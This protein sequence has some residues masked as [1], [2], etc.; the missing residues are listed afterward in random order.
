M[1]IHYFNTDPQPSQSGKGLK[2]HIGLL[3]GGEEM[4]GGSHHDGGEATESLP[5]ARCPLPTPCHLFGV[6]AGPMCRQ[7]AGAASRLG[8]WLFA[9]PS[10]KKAPAA[11]EL[12]S[13]VLFLW[14]LHHQTH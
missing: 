5:S 6:S 2:N 10:P 9:A 11:T 13:H 7:R 1:N 14:G 12:H 8:G 4:Q 3:G